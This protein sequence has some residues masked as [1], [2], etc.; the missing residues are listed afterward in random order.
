M[1]DFEIII[2]NDTSLSIDV[3]DK[4]LYNYD[5]NSY[6]LSSLQKIAG[7]TVSNQI[8]EGLFSQVSKARLIQK[9]A[10]KNNTEYVANISEYAKKKLDSGEWSLGIRKKTGETYAV[11]KDTASGKSKSFITLDARTVNELGNLPELSAIQGQLATISE[12]IQ[13]LNKLVKR[14]EQGQYN[15]RYA[16]FFSARQLVIEGLVAQDKKLK[17]ELLLAAIKTSNQTIAKL[18]FAI[19]QDAN[20]FMDT[21]IKSKEAERIENLLQNS[22][23]YLNITIHLNLVIYSVLGEKDALIS[24]LTNYQSFIEQ[25][26]LKESESGKSVAWKIDNILKGEGHWF[27]E[28]SKGIIKNISNLVDDMTS[29]KIEGGETVKIEAEDM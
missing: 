6:S 14:I 21:K 4:S 5:F 25:T 19:N 10:N 9:L 7:T 2:P 3:T 8:K 27:N 26:L 16:G 29:E 18:M 12:Q 1:K 15:D 23:G 17:N 13:D 22:I 24:T 11:I 20:N 28:L